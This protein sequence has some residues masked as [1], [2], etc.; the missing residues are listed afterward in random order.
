MWVPFII[1][2]SPS[3]WQSWSHPN[4]LVASRYYL[5]LLG[6]IEDSRYSIRTTPICSQ[7]TKWSSREVKALLRLRLCS[8]SCLTLKKGSAR[9]EAHWVDV[10]LSSLTSHLSLTSTACLSLPF[11]AMVAFV[12]SSFPGF[13]HNHSCHLS[14]VDPD[15]TL[16]V[17][18][19]LFSI[20]LPIPFLFCVCVRY[21]IVYLFVN[22]L[23]YLKKNM[24]FFFIIFVSHEN[25][26]SFHE[27]RNF[28]LF[29]PVEPST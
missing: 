22:L 14:D 19:W 29:F 13:Q 1:P 20:E 28:C 23:Y 7:Q 17:S 4:I 16:A 10:P 9:S 3:L 21:N 11:S 15:R 6:T 8:G 25:V 27:L 12:E 26:G 5:V 18:P 24:Y 2:E